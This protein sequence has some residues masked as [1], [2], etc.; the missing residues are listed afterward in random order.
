MGAITPMIG[1]RSGRLTV[2][3]RAAERKNEATWI[4]ECDCGK[5]TRPILGSKLRTGYRI[6]CGCIAKGRPLRMPSPGRGV[7]PLVFFIFEQMEERRFAVDRL[8]RDS[9]VSR[10]A[11]ENVRDGKSRAKLDDIEAML[12]VLGYEL[13]EPALIG[14]KLSAPAKDGGKD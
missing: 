11:I 12:N 9:G 7:H 3:R 8:A 4:C 2:I 13:Q 10:T 6:S 14:S 5:I 1:F